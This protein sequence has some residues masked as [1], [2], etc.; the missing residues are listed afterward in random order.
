MFLNR[1][2][3]HIQFLCSTHITSSPCNLLGHMVVDLCCTTDETFYNFGFLDDPGYSIIPDENK[4]SVR[5]YVLPLSTGTKVH[6][7][8]HLLMVQ[9]D[10]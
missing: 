8:I 6:I 4:Q 1:G 2:V 3:F 10:F 7:H 9:F 5:R